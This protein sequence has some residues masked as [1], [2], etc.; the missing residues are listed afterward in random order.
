MDHHNAKVNLSQLINIKRIG[1][2]RPP[3]TRRF[4]YA[5]NCDLNKEEEEE[6]KHFGFTIKRIKKEIEKNNDS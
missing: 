4:R 5:L 3:N 2:G 1:E 6:E